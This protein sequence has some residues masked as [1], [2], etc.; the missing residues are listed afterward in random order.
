M[1]DKE[2]TGGCQGIL[3]RIMLSHGIVRKCILT[4]LA[5]L[6]KVGLYE[7]RKKEES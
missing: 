3:S 1:E 2:F 7:E 6:D 4:Q 5:K